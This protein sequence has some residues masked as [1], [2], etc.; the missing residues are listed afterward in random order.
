MKA[1]SIEV[2]KMGFAAAICGAVMLAGGTAF[3]ADSRPFS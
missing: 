3:G 2:R 1:M